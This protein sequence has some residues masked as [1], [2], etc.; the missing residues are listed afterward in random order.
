MAGLRAGFTT[1]DL[2][3]MPFPRLVLSLKAQGGPGESSQEDI[4]SVLP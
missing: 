2:R 3:T 4:A 1:G